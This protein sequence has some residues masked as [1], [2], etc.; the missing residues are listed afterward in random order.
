M[1]VEIRE[2]AYADDLFAPLIAEG[3]ATNGTFLLRL[4]DDWISGVR[5]FEEEGEIL[6]G[7]FAGDQLVGVA[8]IS[9]D[10]YA[11]ASGLGRVRHVYV[12]AAW[13]GRGIGRMLMERLIAHARGRFTMLPLSA[14]DRLA[15]IPLYE[16]LGFVPREA[17]KETHRL[18]L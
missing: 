6:L 12:L 11:P 14:R 16:S 5:R 1:T 7:A 18:L 9:H 2:A 13:R 4:R 15:A 17:E 3:Q 10:P 8:G